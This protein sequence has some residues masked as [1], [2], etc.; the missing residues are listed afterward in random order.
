MERMQNYFDTL[1]KG[2]RTETNVDESLLQKLP[3][4]IYMVLI[5]NIVDEFEVCAREG[6]EVDIEDIE[7]AARCL[8]HHIPYA[9]IVE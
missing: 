5:E 6:E 9:G 8:I 4:F 2:Y 7:N 1:L 3:L